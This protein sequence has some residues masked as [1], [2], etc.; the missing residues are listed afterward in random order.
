MYGSGSQFSQYYANAMDSY[1]NSMSSYSQASPYFFNPYTSSQHGTDTNTDASLL[2]SHTALAGNH[3]AGGMTSFG[4]AYSREST[5]TS[6]D[7][8]AF[9][10]NSQT[11]SKNCP[12]QM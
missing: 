2:P 5:P 6:V 9:Q 4:Q 11:S 8:D 3:L 1:P 10:L 12:P 7:N